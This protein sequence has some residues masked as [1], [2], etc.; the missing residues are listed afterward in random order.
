MSDSE[1]DLDTYVTETKYSKETKLP[2]VQRTRLNGLLEAPPDGS[3]S[4]IAFGELG[5]P[6][7]L[8]WHHQN[9]PHR[10]DEPALIFLNPENGVHV[11]EYFFTMGSHRE[12][13]AGPF[14]IVRNHETGEVVREIF[15]GDPDFVETASNPRLEP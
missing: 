13:A 12:K 7:K 2:V 10:D 8:V 14:R 6:V 3:P 1:E 4:E 11:S 5:Q 9:Y 15:E